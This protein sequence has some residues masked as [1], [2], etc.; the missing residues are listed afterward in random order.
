MTRNTATVT[1]FT[2]PVVSL[3]NDTFACEGGT[4]VVFATSGFNNYLWS[5]GET[6]SSIS[7]S[8]TGTFTVTVT[9]ANGCVDDDDITFSNTPV[10][11]S[12]IVDQ[13]FCPPQGV[14]VFGPDGFAAYTWS[15]GG[16]AAKETFTEAGVYSLTVTDIYGCSASTDF[17]VAE[18][19]A[20]GLL[21]PN[22]F[23]PNGDGLND[24]LHCI[25]FHVSSY[26]LKVFNRWGELLFSSNDPDIGWDG[27]LHNQRCPIGTYVYQV[28]YTLDDGTTQT[29]GVK[30]GNITLLR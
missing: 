22:A 13:V 19:C 17:N 12:P 10:T 8:T 25:C 9:D 23:S 6:T 30:S 26:Q 15:T 3:G 4:V 7:I 28:V 14:T 29:H 1:Y 18:Y 11:I 27:T 24:E 21:F 20:P 2:S 16:G 5:T